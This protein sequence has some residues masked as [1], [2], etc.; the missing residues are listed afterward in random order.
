M[1]QNHNIVVKYANHVADIPTAFYN[2]LPAHLPGKHQRNLITQ[3]CTPQEEQNNN[4]SLFG[5][6]FTL[7]N[8]SIATFMYLP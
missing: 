5:L 1:L 4:P 3:R 7:D 6:T 2:H 8:A